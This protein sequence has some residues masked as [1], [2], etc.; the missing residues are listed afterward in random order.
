MQSEIE[1]GV[2]LEDLPPGSMLQV[3]TRNTRYQLLVLIGNMARL[4]DIPCTARV[5][6]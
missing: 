3:T 2:R 5:P 6:S 4:R 1:G